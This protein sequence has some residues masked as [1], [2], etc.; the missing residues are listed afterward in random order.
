MRMHRF[1]E[2]AAMMLVAL[3]TMGIAAAFPAQ[4]TPHFAGPTDQG[5]LL[6]NGWTLKPAGQQIPLADLPLNIVPMADGRHVL[7]ATSGY[8]AH[9]LSVIDL[10]EKKVI[11]KQAVRQSWFGLCDTRGRP[12]LVVGRRRQLTPCISPGRPS[13][14]SNGRGR[15]GEEEGPNRGP[16]PFPRRI[17]AGRSPQGALLAGRGCRDDPFD[18]S[19]DGER[20]S[21]RAGG[22]PAL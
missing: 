13:P 20:N 18:R 21:I 12:D 9:E 3:A 19:G 7:A 4:E 15:A 16:H 8:N 22:R 2:A 5:F 6:P 10:K 14:D 1:R 17:D 11:D